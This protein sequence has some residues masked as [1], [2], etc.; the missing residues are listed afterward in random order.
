MQQR[1]RSGRGPRP[2]GGRGCDEAE[3]PSADGAAG[4][5][6]GRLP[7][8]WFDGEPEVTVDRDEIVVVGRLPG[9][10]GEGDDAQ[11]RAAG[12]VARFRED[13][14]EQRMQIAREAER[15]FAR[16]V[17]WGAVLGD[18]RQVF[19]SLS[20]PV[21]TRLRQFERTVLDTLVEGGVARSRADALAWCVKLVGQHADDGLAE[22]RQSLEAVQRVRSAGPA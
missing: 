11:E 15:R 7:A 8:D 4:W 20:V 6:A 5:F 2:G 18:S 1:S 3:L 9:A 21:M 12:R 10:A 19:T 13:T 14:R 22:R 16:K 17:A